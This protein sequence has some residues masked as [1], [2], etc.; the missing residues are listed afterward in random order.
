MSRSASSTGTWRIP[1]RRLDD[2]AYALAYGRAVPAT[3]MWS[4]CSRLKAT[5][6]VDT[7]LEV[8]ADAYGIK[9]DGLV[10]TVI[11]RR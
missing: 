3:T 1:A 5:R 6:T 9:I 11:E 8:F 4:T 2:V 7:E 10:D